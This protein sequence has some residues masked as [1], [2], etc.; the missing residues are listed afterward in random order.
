MDHSR[1]T[2]LAQIGEGKAHDIYALDERTLR[3]VS[4]DRLSLFDTNMGR[5]VAGKG[6]VMD[7]QSKWWFARTAH[8]VA[9]HLVPPE[10]LDA[11]LQPE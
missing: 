11:L 3:I 9:N 7:S 5:V 4:T 1:L 2:S 8:I 10:R 6:A